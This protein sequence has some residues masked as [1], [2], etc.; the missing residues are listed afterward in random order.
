MVMAPGAGG[1]GLAPLLAGGLG[2]K[3]SVAARAGVPLTLLRVSAVVEV[4][5]VELVGREVL[6]GHIAA[7]ASSLEVVNNVHEYLAS[8]AMAVVPGKRLI[9]RGWRIPSLLLKANT[10]PRLQP[11]RD[12]K[13]LQLL[14]ALLGGLFCATSGGEESHGELDIIAGQHLLHGDR[15]RSDGANVELGNV[16]AI[17][18]EEGLES[19]EG[20]QLWHTWNTYDNTE[21]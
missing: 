6:E 2:C 15:R 9:A 7:G 14:V 1:L 12:H 10:L 13:V 11:T 8:V 16:F 18:T 20:L 5:G 21:T 19:G 3:K 4:D 17:V